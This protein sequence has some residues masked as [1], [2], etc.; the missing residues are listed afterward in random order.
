MIA[1]IKKMLELFGIHN[2]QS[3]IFA[4]QQITYIVWYVDCESHRITVIAGMPPT[5]SQTLL[6]LYRG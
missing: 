6:K 2:K 5:Y 1:N 4:T 3:I